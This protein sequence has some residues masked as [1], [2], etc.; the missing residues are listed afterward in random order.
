[1][2]GGTPGY[3]PGG[4]GHWGRYFPR[5]SILPDG[6]DGRGRPVEAQGCRVMGG[7]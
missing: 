7:K 3:P 4:G 2:D 5:A 1:M 6:I